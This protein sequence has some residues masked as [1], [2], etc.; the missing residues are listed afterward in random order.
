MTDRRGLPV[1]ITQDLPESIPHELPVLAC[2][3][4][5]LDEAILYIDEIEELGQFGLLA[6]S[7]A[8]ELLEPRFYLV[9]RGFELVVINKIHRFASKLLSIL[10]LGQLLD[11][12][13]L[14]D[15]LL[16][17]L[18]LDG[19]GGLEAMSE[20][21]DVRDIG[22]YVLSKAVAV[23]EQ[24]GQA[25]ERIRRD[26]RAL[27]AK[28]PLLVV[29]GL[30]GPLLVDVVAADGMHLVKKRSRLELRQ[31]GAGV[32]LL[33]LLFGALAFCGH[34]YSGT[35]SANLVGVGTGVGTR[36]SGS[37]GGPRFAKSRSRAHERWPISL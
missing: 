14:G 29:E 6:S 12:D 25:L 37:G 2:L 15:H 35:L 3:P 22:L 18:A 33:I 11:K 26:E 5:D 13:R 27:V 20:A 1:S 23:L 7:Q 24:K 30:F 21:V 10:G 8:P 4:P 19:Q 31:F 16:S 34:A 28:D 36:L 17:V 32:V 9:R